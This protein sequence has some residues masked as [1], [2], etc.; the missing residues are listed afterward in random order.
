[1]LNSVDNRLFKRMQPVM[2]VAKKS[3]YQQHQQRRANQQSPPKPFYANAKSHLP[4][5][6]IF[7]FH[8]RMD[9]H[10]VANTSIL[11]EK[12]SIQSF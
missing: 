2:P 3:S 10:Y 7:S 4:P 9:G 5:E 12:P 11:L 1:M 6:M 8:R